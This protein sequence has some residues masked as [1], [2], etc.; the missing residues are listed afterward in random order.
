MFLSLIINEFDNENS[1][2][3]IN[4]LKLVRFALKLF[5]IPKITL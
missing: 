5:Q 3:T 1:V 2:E 4:Y